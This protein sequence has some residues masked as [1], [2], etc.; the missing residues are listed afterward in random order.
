MAWLRAGPTASE[1]AEII[2]LLVVVRFLL[3]FSFLVSSPAVLSLFSTFNLR[4]F[5]RCVLP[6]PTNTD[7]LVKG[8]FSLLCDRDTR[9][10]ISSAFHH[11]GLWI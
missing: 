8:R 9:G 10:P 2:L 1:A 3:S 4:L 7:T 11:T 5:C 6:L